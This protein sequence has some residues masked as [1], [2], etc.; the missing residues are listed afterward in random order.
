MRTTAFERARSEDGIVHWIRLDDIVTE[1]GRSTAEGSWVPTA[2]RG[3]CPACLFDRD[4]SSSSSQR[5]SDPPSAPQPQEQANLLRFLE[6]VQVKDLH[7]VKL[8]GNDYFIRN[9]IGVRVTFAV[10]ASQI[11]HVRELFR[12]TELGY[13]DDN[14][15]SHV[16][17]DDC[18]NWQRSLW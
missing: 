14:G 16:R 9:L 2:A 13:C 1:C 17:S 5:S 18:R 6:T 12:Q 8:N 3:S 4:T 15:L 10:P 11:D 7:I